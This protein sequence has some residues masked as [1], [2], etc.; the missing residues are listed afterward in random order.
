MNFFELFESTKPIIGVVHLKPLPGAPLYDNFNDVLEWAVKDAKNLEDGGVDGVIVEN[1]NDNPFKIR[2]TEPETIAAMSVVAHEVKKELS[3]PVG[4]S[5]LRNSA[6]EALG[7]AFVTNLEFIRVNVFVESVV[8]DSGLINAIAPEL[9]RYR[10][11]LSAN[12][13]V[14]ADVNVK[15]AAPIGNRQIEDIILDAFERGCAD[16]V[17]IT[18]RRTGK[19][20]DIK[21][22]IAARAVAS[23]AILIG[24]GLNMKNLDL[25]SNADGAIVG[26]YFHEEGNISKPVDKKRVELL[27]SEVKRMYG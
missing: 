21:V 4:I 22:L 19:P 14:F 24:S 13:G 18:G 1:Y 9:I 10:K 27:M 16:A 12:I 15:H 8:T 7:I 25:L 5:F 3:I 11:K 20:P 2:V 23:G 17:I 6:I 26:T